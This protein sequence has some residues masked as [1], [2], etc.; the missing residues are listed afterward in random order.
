MND[1]ARFTVQHLSLRNIINQ[2]SEIRNTGPLRKAPISPLD[3]PQPGPRRKKEG[4]KGETYGL[5]ACN[6]NVCFIYPGVSDRASL[7]SAEA[8]A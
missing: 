5:L 2:K 4:H 1:D 6:R 8:A 7:R 3:Y